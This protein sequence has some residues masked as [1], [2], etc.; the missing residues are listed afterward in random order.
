MFLAISQF[1]W[2][3]TRAH[4]HTH[5]H[6]GVYD[7]GVVGLYPSTKIITFVYLDLNLMENFEC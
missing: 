7:K 5:T 4:T 6:K 2:P 1:H 3:I